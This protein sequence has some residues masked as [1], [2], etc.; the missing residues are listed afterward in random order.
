MKVE[1]DLPELELGYEYTG[2]FR[3]PTY[4]ELFLSSSGMVA[5]C[6]TN[7]LTCYPAPIIRKKTPP[8]SPPV[9]VFKSGWLVACR[10]YVY[11]FQEKPTW[12]VHERCWIGKKYDS[13]RYNLPRAIFCES[14]LPPINEDGP[15]AI[16]E[17]K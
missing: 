10:G 8:Y 5:M 3:S 9:G 12:S 1:I 2:E 6:L 11:W 13:V 4:N 17:V 15:E 16:W 14:E 7:S